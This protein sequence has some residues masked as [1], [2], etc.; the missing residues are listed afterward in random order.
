L[1]LKLHKAFSSARL[2][3]PILEFTVGQN[4]KDTVLIYQLRAAMDV[5]SSSFGK[6]LRLEKIQ[7][8]IKVGFKRNPRS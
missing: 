2:I 8:Y 3:T 1:N 5:W 6:V 7:Y 4:R